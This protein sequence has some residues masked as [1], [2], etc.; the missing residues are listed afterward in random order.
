MGNEDRDRASGDDHGARVLL[1]EDDPD[2]SKMMTRLLSSD[3][4]RVVAVA[5]GEAALEA[6]AA[7][8]PKVIVADLMLPKMD[9]EEFLLQLRRQYAD[10]RSIPVI[11]VTASAIREEVA[12]RAEVAA[13]LAK[14]FDTDELRMLVRDFLSPPTHPPSRE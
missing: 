10:A 1:V 13:S 7:E 11:L 8:M 9:G 12:A 3:G 5:D 6:C 4:H 2:L 14:P